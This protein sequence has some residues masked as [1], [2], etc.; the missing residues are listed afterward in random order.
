MRARINTIKKE[1]GTHA[2]PARSII[3]RK[4]AGYFLL[5]ALSV[6]LVIHI[7]PQAD[8]GLW[9]RSVDSWERSKFKYIP[10]DLFQDSKQ[11]RPGQRLLTF[12]LKALPR[13]V[14]PSITPIKVLSHK[15]NVVTANKGTRLSI[16]SHAFVD[17]RGQPIKEPVTLRVIEIVDPLDF[18]T[19]G[20]SLEYDPPNGQRQYFKSAGMFRIGASCN[21][22]PVRLARGKKIGVEF[23]IIQ[24]G[25]DFFV[26]KRDRHGRWHRH[27]H[28]QANEATGDAENE[29][30]TIG[31]RR[32]KIDDLNKWWNFDKPLPKVACVTGK[33][34]WHDGLQPQG[35][36]VYSIGIS[37]KG[38][39]SRYFGPSKGFRVNVHKSS[40]ARFMVIDKKGNIGISPIIKVWDKTGF[41]RPQ[42]GS[43]GACQQIQTIKVKKLS[44]KVLSSKKALSRHL[45]LSVSRYTVDYQNKK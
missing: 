18:V 26:Y 16:P 32:Y 4:I 45:G 25:N 28:N 19:S 23:P 5:L 12:I 14:L 31:T 13:T 3:K 29:V 35:Y 20:V 30:P 24:P 10:N 41:D 22:K 37:Y 34:V 2:P 33:V 43:N 38:A 11:R 7:G 39:F 21:G 42:K 9:G 6:S 15:D 8:G 27:G 1:S 17:Q 40:R 36:R 44:Q